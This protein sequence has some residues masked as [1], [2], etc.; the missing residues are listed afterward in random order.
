MD[1]LRNVLEIHWNLREW[2]TYTSTPKEQL[3][4]CFNLRPLALFSRL[5]GL[6]PIH[7][8][9]AN[10]ANILRYRAFSPL[11]AY[12]C[13]LYSLLAFLH[14]THFIYRYEFLRIL[15]MWADFRFL[16]GIVVFSLAWDT[17]IILLKKFDE[18]DSRFRLLPVKIY[19]T[20]S[21]FRR[22][23]FLLIPVSAV[24]YTHLD[25]YK[26]QFIT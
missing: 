10:A 25:V 2:G 22:Y 14:I 9:S 20:R 13:L 24:S 1:D 11:S 12:G 26:R 21:K 6:F 3:S 19:C 16:I 18:F 5:L 23:V 15:S 8:V 17:Y 7:N 4:V